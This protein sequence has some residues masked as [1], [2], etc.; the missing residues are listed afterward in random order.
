MLALTATAACAAATGGAH[1]GLVYEN[2]PVSAQ[3]GVSDAFSSNGAYA[4]GQSLA[5][6][7]SIEDAYDLT[8]LSFWG[9]SQD[10]DGTDLANIVAFNVVVWNADFT[11]QVFNWTIA[12]NAFAL[13]ATGNE[14]VSGGAEYRFDT[15][16]LGTLSA[17]TYNINIGGVLAN[18]SGN[19]F[20]WSAGADETGRSFTED[21]TW[22][23]WLAVPNPIGD[24]GFGAFRLDGTIVPAP[25]AFAAL[26][27]AGGLGRRRRR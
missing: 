8:G 15:A 25:A 17:G 26:A 6:R 18:G 10:F 3:G 7:F 19:A 9:S 24:D 14:N 12:T 2:A 4:F 13:T 21:P 16:I 22:G 20:V 11:A 23:T 5:Q 27:L 1:A